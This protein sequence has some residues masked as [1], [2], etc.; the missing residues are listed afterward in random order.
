VPPM[1]ARR[2]LPRA[3]PVGE[4]TAVLHD[5][6]IQRVRRPARM[7]PQCTPT[8][9]ALA[10]EIQW[11][12]HRFVQIDRVESQLT[13]AARTCADANERNVEEP[14]SLPPPAPPLSLLPAVSGVDESRLSQPRSPVKEPIEK[15]A[16]T[17]AP[18]PTRAVAIALKLPPTT[19]F[20]WG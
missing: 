16:P 10:A 18:R 19:L 7:V 3:R 17:T 6:L 20:C 9:C 4:P 2:T 12:L 14:K 5:G 13:I 8:A 1:V 11:I 15:S